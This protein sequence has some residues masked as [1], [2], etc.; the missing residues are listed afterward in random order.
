M[1]ILFKKADIILILFFCLLCAALLIPRYSGSGNMTAVIYESGKI[2]H[3]I[4]LSKVSESYTIKLANAPAS[5]VEV[6]H[7]GIRY[8]TASCPDK[9]CVKAGLLTHR[10]DTAACLPQK[11]V[12]VIEGGSKDEKTPDVITY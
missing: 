5:T 6:E 4:D 10:G 3:R 7:N 2:T 9:L 8:L 12:I 11:T 1:K